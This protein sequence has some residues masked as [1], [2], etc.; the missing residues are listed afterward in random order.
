[1]IQPDVIKEGWIL[2]L[3][4]IAAV[5]EARHVGLRPHV[6]HRSMDVLPTLYL[7]ASTPKFMVNGGG[8]QSWFQ[9]ALI[10]DI[11]T[12]KDGFL[13]LPILGSEEK[14]TKSGEA[15]ILQRKM[16]KTGLHL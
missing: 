6:I 7:D 11:P 16:S 14:W 12:Q 1:M 15:S 3:K 8:A 2:E 9:E 10:A 5:A 13:W 4:N